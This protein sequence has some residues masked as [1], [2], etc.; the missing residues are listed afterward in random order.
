M[1]HRN[2]PCPCR[3]S[4][5]CSVCKIL[6]A[7]RTV[8]RLTPKR[9]INSASAGSFA[10]VLSDSCMIISRSLSATCSGS[11]RVFLTVSIALAFPSL[12][13]KWGF[14]FYLRLRFEVHR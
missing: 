14:E 10:P 6:T 9:S 1:A 5:I 12:L 7:S 3:I 2:V 8:E 4:T 13:T 11:F